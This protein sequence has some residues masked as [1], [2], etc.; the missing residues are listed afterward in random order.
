MTR[1]FSVDRG[2]S[3][4]TRTRNENVE[5]RRGRSVTSDGPFREEFG[6]RIVDATGLGL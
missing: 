1:N 2:N 4:S 6:I 5:Q 3:R